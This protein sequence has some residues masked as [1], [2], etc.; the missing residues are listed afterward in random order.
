MQRDEMTAYKTKITRHAIHI[1]IGF[2]SLWGCDNPVVNLG[3]NIQQN[4]ESSRST[5]EH[6][7]KQQWNE[8]VD[9]GMKHPESLPQ[10]TLWDGNY[11]KDENLNPTEVQSDAPKDINPKDDNQMPHQGTDND[12]NKRIANEDSDAFFEPGSPRL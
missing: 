4:I 9:A 1:L 11:D 7:D 5:D 10:N 12:Q 3:S 8:H 6:N 2:A